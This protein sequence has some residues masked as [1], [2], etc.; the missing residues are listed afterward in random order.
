MMK[1]ALAVGAFA[2]VMALPLVSTAG[3]I[4]SVFAGS[5]SISGGANDLVVGDTISFDVFLTLDAGVSYNGLSFSVTG[6][7]VGGL[8]SNAGISWA[9]VANQVA[10]WTWYSP[11]I[12]G[13]VD[14]TG[15]SGFGQPLVN[16][17]PT[18]VPVLLGQAVLGTFNGL[19]NSVLVGTVTILAD[20]V[21]VFGG[22]AIMH[23]QPITDAFGLQ[24]GLIDPVVFTTSQFTVTPEPGT[25]LLVGV[26]LVGLAARRR[27]L[28]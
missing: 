23:N 18:P 12:P 10:S 25:A 5:S 17:L 4:T 21:G 19:G 28:R 7:E 13:F 26:G 2:L 27:R 20:T 8:A 15:A 16:T 11:V 9:G 1:K 24:G 6:D 3:S 14:F 22:G